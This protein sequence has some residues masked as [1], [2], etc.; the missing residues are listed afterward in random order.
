MCNCHRALIVENNANIKN[1]ACRG[2]TINRIPWIKVIAATPR[3]IIKKKKMKNTMHLY[4]APHYNAHYS[5][6]VYTFYTKKLEYITMHRAGS[7]NAT[8]RDDYYN[9][10]H[11]HTQHHTGCTKSST[12]RS[13]VLHLNIMS[14]CG[15]CCF[16]CCV[17]L[18]AMVVTACG[19]FQNKIFFFVCVHFTYTACCCFVIRGI[20]V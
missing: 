10:H 12:I 2:A 13:A 16:Y 19:G 14:R 3:I 9:A 11:T 5:W 17:C 7:L 6:C 4:T 20:S 1:C 18:N 8:G 15:C